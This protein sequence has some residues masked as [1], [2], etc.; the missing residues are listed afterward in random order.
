MGTCGGQMWNGR[1][2]MTMQS[3]LPRKWRKT[4]GEEEDG[5]DQTMTEKRQAGIWDTLYMTFHTDNLLLWAV[6]KF[7]KILNLHGAYLC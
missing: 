6:S 2:N 1:S 4:R 3:D 5:D 7:Y